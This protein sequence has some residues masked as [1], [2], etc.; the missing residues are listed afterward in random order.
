M[1]PLSREE[2]KKVEEHEHPLLATSGK[3]FMVNVTGK[4]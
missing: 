2:T 3:V 1:S 4:Y